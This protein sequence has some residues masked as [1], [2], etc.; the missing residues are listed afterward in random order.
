MKIIKNEDHMRYKR[1]AI[2]ILLFFGLGFAGVQAQ[3]AINSTGGKAEGSG[4][5]VS[6]SIGQVVYNT[7]SGFSGTLAEGVQQPFE[8]SVITAVE[9]ASGIVLSVSAYPNPTVDVLTLAISDFSFSNLRF[10]IH[11]MNGKLLQKA[12]IIS[13]ETELNMQDYKADAYLLRIFRNN[14]VLKTFKIIL[15]L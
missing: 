5:S 4:G 11:D 12:V 7:H 6:Y 8:I 15:N 1:L 9:E 14:Q 2:S 10:Q 13:N 3:E